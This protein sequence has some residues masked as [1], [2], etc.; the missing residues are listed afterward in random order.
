VIENVSSRKLQGEVDVILDLVRLVRQGTFIDAAAVQPPRTT[1]AA[2]V[3]ERALQA[4]S[5]MQQM[6][7]HCLQYVFLRTTWNSVGRHVSCSDCHRA[8]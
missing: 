5:R 4:Q 1:A 8:S 7:V 2:L 3:E 6:K